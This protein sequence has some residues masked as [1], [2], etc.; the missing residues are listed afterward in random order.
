MIFISKKIPIKRSP[1]KE[2]EVIRKRARLSGISIIHQ[3][4]FK[5]CPKEKHLWWLMPQAFPASF[6]TKAGKRMR[7]IMVNDLKK[8]KNTKLICE[9]IGDEPIQILIVYYLVNTEKNRDVD[10]YTKNIIDSL[11][12]GGLFTDDNNRQVRF[13]ASKVN[14]INVTNYNYYRAFEKAIIIVDFFD[15]KSKIVSAFDSN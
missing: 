9:K 8:N 11:K 12:D 6:Q 15:E 10:N 7:K 4:C 2:S 3:D 14:F 5:G 1:K 13:V